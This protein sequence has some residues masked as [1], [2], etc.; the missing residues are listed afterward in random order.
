[1]E[2]I[3][4]LPLIATWCERTFRPEVGREA[5]YRH[6]FYELA[7]GGALAFF[8]WADEEAWEKNRTILSSRRGAGGI[9]PL[10]VGSRDPRRDS[11]RRV[12]GRRG[13]PSDRRSRLRLPV[14]LCAH[15][16]RAQAGVHRRRRPT[17]RRSAAMRR[18]GRAQRARSAGWGATAAPTTT[19]GR[20]E[21]RLLASAA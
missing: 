1:M 10:K 9:S 5:D 14:A 13:R 18:C 4:G 11:K 17:P 19:T 6:T 2:D 8:Q 7:D 16:R 20:T 21:P 12:E 15:A 3:L